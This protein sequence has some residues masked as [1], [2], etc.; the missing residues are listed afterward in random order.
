[1]RKK[2]QFIEKLT[3]VMMIDKSDYDNSFLFSFFL[4]SQKRIETQTKIDSCKI[5]KRGRMNVSY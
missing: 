1:M 3:L 2:K 4:S 5:N